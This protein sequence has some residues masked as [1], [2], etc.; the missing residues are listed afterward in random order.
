[1]DSVKM[2][3]AKI[4]STFELLKDQIEDFRQIKGACVIFDSNYSEYMHISLDFVLNSKLLISV[5]ES[6]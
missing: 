6:L 3:A 4:R 1:M 2:K 5:T